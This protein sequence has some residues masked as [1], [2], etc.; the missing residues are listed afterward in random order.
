MLPTSRLFIRTV[1]LDDEV[2]KVSENIANEIEVQETE[3]TT[4]ETYSYEPTFCDKFKN[5][6]YIVR[7]VCCFTT[8]FAL[9]SILFIVLDMSKVGDFVGSLIGICA[10]IGWVSVIFACPWKMLKLCFKI[11]SRAFVIGLAF[12]GVGCVVGLMIGVIISFALVFVVPFII[13]IPH[14]FNE[15]M[16][17]D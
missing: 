7:C 17:T 13:T 12:M 11:I 10:I 5:V 16:Y 15:L 6:F 2:T 9:S 1:N 3:N 14:F 8:I 4:T